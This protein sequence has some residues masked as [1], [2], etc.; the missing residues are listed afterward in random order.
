MTADL[1]CLGFA[2]VAAL[3]ASGVAARWLFFPPAWWRPAAR[4]QR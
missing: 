2:F 4:G 1:L 3:A